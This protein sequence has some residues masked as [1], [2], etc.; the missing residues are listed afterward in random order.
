MAISE[1]V[2]VFFSE[3][4]DDL[5]KAFVELMDL[6]IYIVTAEAHCFQSLEGFPMAL[7]E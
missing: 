7:A 2:F 1:P 3:V 6:D 5:Q 4:P